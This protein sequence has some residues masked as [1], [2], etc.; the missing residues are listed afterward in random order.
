MKKK[1]LALCLVVALAATAVVGTTLAYFSDKDT[2]NNVVTMGSVDI[3]L[4]EA[5]VTYDPET[6]QWSAGEERVKSNT[7]DAV[8]PGAVMPKDPTVHN[9]G[10]MDA[11]VRVKV[12]VTGYKN[13][14]FL[15]GARGNMESP[16]HLNLL[17]GQ[18]GEGWTITEA[19]SKGEDMIYTIQYG[20]I[21]KANESTTPVFEEITFPTDFSRRT[22]GDSQEY[23]SMLMGWDRTF[24][25]NV[26]A[27]AIQAP[28]FENIDDAFANFNPNTKSFG[29]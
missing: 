21:L 10:T 1:I 25:I 6:Y 22:A 15:M 23:A 4:D 17:V 26:V 3:V 7:Y 2:N 18:L 11:Y 24:N 27:E 16:E 29:N 12:T 9:E 14:A 13:W 20:T 5:K 19:V 28:G 8:Y